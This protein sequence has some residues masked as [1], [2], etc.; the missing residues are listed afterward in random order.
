[1]RLHE[2]QAK[3]LLSGHGISVPT[4]QPAFTVAE[5][6][7]AA[8]SMTPP[9][10]IKSQIHS[11]GRGKAGGILSAGTAAEAEAAAALLLGSRLVTA[12]SGPRGMPVNAVLVEQSIAATR[13]FYVGLLVDP[14]R[15]Q[16]VLLVSVHGGMDIEQVASEHPE[17][18]VSVAVDP[19]TGL[20]HYQVRKLVRALNLTGALAT[21]VAT[22][23]RSVY[24]LFVENDCTLVEINP[25][26]ITDKGELVALDAKISIDDNAIFRRPDMAALKDDTQI[27]LLEREAAEAGVSYVKMDGAIGCLVNGAGLAMATMDIV[28]L[29]GGRPAN[30]LD[31]GGTAD[32]DRICRAVELLLNDPDVK[33]AWINIFGGILRCDMVARALLRVLA[34]RRPSIPFVVRMQGTN[35]DE[36]RALLA[37]GPMNLMLESDLARAARLAVAATGAPSRRKRGV[38]S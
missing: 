12:Q 36:A 14:A 28:M 5:A 32:E 11:G 7:S 1:M 19:L 31:V 23:L 2:F 29:L 4:G 38:A 20:L 33:V 18:L 26:V 10:V 16:P 8:Q 6:L 21:Q 25:L 37:S 9:L 34:Q 24:R 3:R 27:D 17:T 22:L 35:A 13:E 15:K 30:F